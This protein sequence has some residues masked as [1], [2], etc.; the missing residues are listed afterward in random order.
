MARI[1]RLEQLALSALSNQNHPTQHVAE[2]M[3]FNIMPNV[4][5][6]GSALLP[7]T[8]E[9]CIIENDNQIDKLSS[10]FGVMKVDPS[11]TIY[12]GGAHWVSVMSEVMC[13][14]PECLN[15]DNLFTDP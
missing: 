3:Q 2:T 7:T 12:L 6:G 15:P 13:K 9:A 1:N 4:T 5:S 10:A 11:Q 8:H 14:E